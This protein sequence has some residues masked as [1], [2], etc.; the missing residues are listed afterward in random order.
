MEVA[1]LVLSILSKYGPEAYR[2]ARE[3]LAT[4]EPTEAQFAKLD[5]IL[6]KTGASYFAQRVTL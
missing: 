6:E 2:A 5:A 1:M 3:I 4:K